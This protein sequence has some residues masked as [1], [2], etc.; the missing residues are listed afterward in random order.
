MTGFCLFGCLFLP[1]FRAA[2]TAFGSSQA[3]GRIGAVAAGLRHSTSVPNPNWDSL[4]DPQPIEWG[5]GLN[6]CPHDLLAL[7]H[8]GNSQ[9]KRYF[10]PCVTTIVKGGGPQDAV[11]FPG[12]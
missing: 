9:G 3:R 6:L 1:L 8:K 2:P 7:S 4:L 11:V 5:Q 10:V 12:P